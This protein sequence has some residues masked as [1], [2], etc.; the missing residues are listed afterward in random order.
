LVEETAVK[1]LRKQ[2]LPSGGL[3][4]TLVVTSDELVVGGSKR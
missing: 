3:V 4:P 1:C 2:V